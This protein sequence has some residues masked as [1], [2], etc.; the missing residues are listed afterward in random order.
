VAPRSFEDRLKAEVEAAATCSEIPLS[1]PDFAE[2]K[3]FKT[4]LP[5]SK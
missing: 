4:L 1:C 2:P 5:I 3:L